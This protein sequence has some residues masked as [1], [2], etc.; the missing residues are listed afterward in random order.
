MFTTDA[1]QSSAVQRGSIG[2]VN[3]IGG[4]DRL[5]ISERRNEAVGGRTDVTP[6]ICTLEKWILDHREMQQCLLRQQQYSRDV[7]LKTRLRV[8]IAIAKA[9]NEYHKDSNIHGKLSLSSF[10]LH[11]SD[12]ACVAKLVKV[13]TCDRRRRLNP[14]DEDPRTLEKKLDLDGL[15]KIYRLLFGDGELSPGSD[16]R[17]G[18]GGMLG[19][20]NRAKRG[21]SPTEF[22]ILEDLPL[23]LSSLISGL[24]AGEGECKYRSMEAVVDDLNSA[25]LHFQPTDWVSLSGQGM[26]LPAHAF[27]G[28]QAELAALMNSLN[29]GL[30]SG[31]P[32]MAVISG[33]S[34][35]GKSELVKQAESTIRERNGYMV[36]GKFDSNGSQ[37][38]S[39]LYRA[40]DSFFD[41]FVEMSDEKIKAEMK[42]RIISTV[43][44]GLG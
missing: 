19:L 5:F 35:F 38:D 43:G 32:A 23:Y 12:G 3:G 17:N 40:L 6:R 30:N 16:L 26:L 15:G 42:Q 7:D 21:K 14:A 22:H 18:G 8:A 1:S 4:L 9:L 36:C 41:S 24:S 28:R 13:K 34:G 11:T 39:V 20:D 33:R 31:A 25:H 2:S 37:S 29:S 10:I 27:Y 44:F